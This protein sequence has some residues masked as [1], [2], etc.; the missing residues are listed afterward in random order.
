M[1]KQRPTTEEKQYL[2]TELTE[3]RTA[4]EKV[5]TRS[6]LNRKQRAEV[7]DADERLVKLERTFE[8]I[9]AA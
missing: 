5:K 3:L 1:I 4:L 9:S 6:G 7:A 2:E 8:K